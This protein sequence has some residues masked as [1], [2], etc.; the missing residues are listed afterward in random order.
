MKIIETMCPRDCYDS[1]LLTVT[2][3]NDQILSIKGN[4][5]NPVTQGFTCARGAR[6][7][8]RVYSPTRILHPYIRQNEQT[9]SEFTKS[10]WDETLTLVSSTLQN[11]LE[12][13]GAEAVLHLEFAGNMG[14]L[15]WYYPQRFWNALGATKTDYSIC[16]KSGHEAIALHYGRSYGLQPEELLTM[17]LITYWGF[18]AKI[19]SSHLWALSLKARRNE[20]AIIVVVDP[21]RSQTAQAADLW[22]QPRP[23]SDVALAYGIARYLIEQDYVNPDF[24]HKWTYGYDSFKRETMFWTPE[25]IEEITN[26]KW[27]VIETLG[28]MYWK[29]HPNAT[30]IGL[31]LQ[32]SIHGAESARAVSL[33]PALLGFH[34]GFY[35]SNSGRWK[36]NLPY[37]TGEAW[38]DQQPKMV[39]QVALGKLLEAGMFRFLMVYN[40][41]PAVTLPDQASVRN[42][43]SREDLFVVVHDTH[44]TETAKFADV[45]LPAPTFLEKEDIV[46]SYSHAYTRCAQRAIT[47]LAESRDEI[48]L[49]TELANRLNLKTPRLSENPWKAVEKALGS[50]SINRTS[51]VTLSS[52]ASNEYQTPTR[53]IEFFS[54]VAASA[55][56]SPLPVQL[57]IEHHPEFFILLNTASPCYTHSQFQEIYGLI[58]PRIWINSRDAAERD[59]SHGDVI[60]I[61]NE[62]GHLEL[63]AHVT[64]DILQHVLWAPRQGS[65]IEE[66]A[67]NWITP[68][69]TQSLGGGPI[70]NS[71]RVT[72]T[73][74]NPG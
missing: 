3:H 38:M 4:S 54:K 32:K 17:K 67:Q 46:I 72:V 18:N 73:K 70:F 41:N 50:R 21:R 30:M 24:L 27:T 35:F 14:L 37:I 45:V 68:P 49:V 1:C 25:K 34:R 5:N 74:K 65:G 60:S 51:I 6:D 10:T 39:S 22:V 64:A 23:G 55:N 42:G 12:C 56:M 44:W 9:D 36:V 7:R 13:Y 66:I 33:I 43:L 2:V 57:P 20:D 59:I 58:P 53:K 47:P 48:W 40:M 31:G 71:T 26:V 63:Q 69:I 52:R 8:D 62:L 29:N 19:S 16:G 15:T 61:R 28:E 11:V